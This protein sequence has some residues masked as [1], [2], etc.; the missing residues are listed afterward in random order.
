MPTAGDLKQRLA[1]GPA[2]FDLMAILGQP[3]D[4]IN[5]STATWPEGSR[6]QVKLDAPAI[7]DIVPDGAQAAR[8]AVGCGC[9]RKKRSISAVA[10]GPRGSV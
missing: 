4:V 9:A 6:R 10:S 5:D 1:K 7:T 8:A 2:T 3:G